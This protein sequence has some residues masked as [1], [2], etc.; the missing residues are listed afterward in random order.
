M[1]YALLRR[2]IKQQEAATAAFKGL[3][4]DIAQ[5]LKEL[6]VEPLAMLERDDIEG[7][8]IHIKSLR[9]ESD[10]LDKYWALFDS[11]QRRLMKELW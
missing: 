6:A 3:D 10:E 9:L 5:G 4:P 8:V 11:T 7:A 2:A 1:K